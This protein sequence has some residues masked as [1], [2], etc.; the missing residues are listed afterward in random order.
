MAMGN[1]YQTFTELQAKGAIQSLE[2]KVGDHQAHYLKADSGVV[3][4]HGGASD[5]R[6]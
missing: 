1:R 6:D 3:L 5:S 4:L 2:L